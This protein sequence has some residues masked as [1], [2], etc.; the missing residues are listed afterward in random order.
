MRAITY[1]NTKHTLPNWVPFHQEQPRGFAYETDTHFVHVFGSGD[2]LWTISPGLTVTEAKSGA[3]TDWA[4]RTFGAVDIEDVDLDVGSTVEGVWRPG[5]Y[6]EEELITGLAITGTERRLAEQALLLLI[7]RLD[8]LLNFI[9]PSAETLST[10]SH[11]TRE[12]LLLSCMEVESY[13]RGYLK[14]AGAVT[15]MTSTKHYVKLMPRLFL[16]EYEVSLPRYSAIPPMCPFLNWA[17]KPSPTKTLPWYD[18]YNQTKHDRTAHFDQA[19]LS[20]CL[21]AVAAALILF[22][23]RFGPF[24]VFRGGGS[25]AVLCNQL[26]SLTLQRCRPRSFYVPKIAIPSDL[27]SDLICFD[28]RKMILPRKPIGLVI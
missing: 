14:K 19:T 23:V 8:E 2:G 1:R 6:F 7:V 4:K 16:D 10:Y 21:Q 3:L 28:A 11:K 22:A 17:E 9:E 13:W 25:F 18:A 5:L 20:N 26:F 15:R 27:R 12:L 24:P